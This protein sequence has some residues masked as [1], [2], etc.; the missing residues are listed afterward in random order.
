MI[1]EEDHNAKRTEECLARIKSHTTTRA[2]GVLVLGKTG[3]GKSSIAELATGAA[4]TTECQIASVVINQTERFIIDTP[5]FDGP[6]NA[7]EI[8]R[9][10]ME[11]IED[12]RD[13][14]EIVGVWF[15]VSNWDIRHGLFEKK[16][17]SWLEALCG[18][19][20]FRRLTFVTT[21]WGTDEGDELKRHNDRLNF[22]LSN[23]WGDFIR[24]GA[25]HHQFGKRHVHGSEREELLSWTRDRDELAQRARNMLELY[26]EEGTV[27]ET[28]FVQE[29][30]DGK[31]LDQTT[32]AR[33]FRPI[34]P[35]PSQEASSAPKTNPPQQPNRECP[36]K[37]SENKP[38]DPLVEI[39]ADGSC[40]IIV[41]P[42]DAEERLPE[43]WDSMSLEDKLEW[44][45]IPS[46]FET[47]ALMWRASGMLGP[48]TGSNAQDEIIRHS[49]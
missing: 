5:G 43:N 19:F 31:L 28:L 46:Y 30:R 36:P 13:H 7:W 3:A 22:R 38:K 33:I 10:I 12:I 32:A 24:R 17:C 27:P 21:F 35:G 34:G 40:K 37:A 42:Q 16:L 44:M 9:K 6:D 18:Q 1:S 47:R 41:P 45:E 23:N 14:L 2:K 49:I 25:C 15:L 4:G 48:Y 26:C 39:L 8:A 29:L 11:L 20:F